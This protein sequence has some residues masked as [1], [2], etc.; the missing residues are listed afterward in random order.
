MTKREIFLN[1][2][3]TGNILALRKSV[4]PKLRAFE[5]LDFDQQTGMW[6]LQDIIDDFVSY[7]PDCAVSRKRSERL[8]CLNQLTKRNSAKIVASLQS[9]HKL[10]NKPVK[11]SIKENWADILNTYNNLVD[12]R[13]QCYEGVDDWG[14]FEVDDFTLQDRFFIEST[15]G[16]WMPLCLVDMDATEAEN[17]VVEDEMEDEE[18]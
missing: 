2:I 16:D 6:I 10:T 17:I 1:Q 12:R 14:D 3:N 9:I 5:I 13:F 8:Q 18:V 7:Q 15:N 4:C 11:L